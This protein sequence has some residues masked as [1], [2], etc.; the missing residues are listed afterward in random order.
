[1]GASTCLKSIKLATFGISNKICNKH[2]KNMLPR[3]TV[4][5]TKLANYPDNSNFNLQ[6]EMRLLC[7]D[8][9]QKPTEIYFISYVQ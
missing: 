9:L 1:M 7:K 8:K 5:W 6:I 4:L 3:I 2:S